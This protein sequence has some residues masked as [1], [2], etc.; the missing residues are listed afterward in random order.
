[1]NVVPLVKTGAGL[2]ASLSAGNVVGNIIKATTPE[3]LSKTK[4]LLTLAGGLVVSAVIADLASTYVEDQIQDVADGFT[5][6]RAFSERVK[7]AREAGAASVDEEDIVVA[8]V[9]DDEV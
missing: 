8:E 2:I 7:A 9:V 1:M 3:N 4:K 6:G 5:F